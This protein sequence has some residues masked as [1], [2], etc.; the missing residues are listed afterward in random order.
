MNNH[1]VI[2]L[3]D[4]FVIPTYGRFPLAFKSGS[5][6]RIRDFEGKEYLDF[7]TGIAVCALGHANP[8]L[9]SAVTQQAQQL[10]HTSNLYYTE[11]Q[12][13]LAEKVV[14][15][16]GP[17]KCF[18]CNSGAEANEALYKLARKFGH[19]AGKYEVL[20]TF[21]SFHGRTLAGIAATGQDKVKK[22]FEPAVEGF[23]HVPFNDLAAMEKAIGPK[24]AAILIETVQGES[25][26]HPVSREYLLGLRKLCDEKGLLLMLDAVQCG[27]FRTGRF[28]SFQRILEKTPGDK[29]DF[30]P[31]AISMAKGLGGGIPIGLIWV[32]DTY[33]GIL[34][35]G[36]HGSTFGGTPIACAASLKV[37]EVIER[38]HLDDNARKLGEYLVS[39][40]Q[41]LKSPLIQEVRGIGL[42]IG[43]ELKSN[44]PSLTI[45]G[46]TAA[47]IFVQKL[48][49][50]GLLT[51][52]SGAATI[53][54]LPAMNIT[55]Q[56]CDEAVRII[57]EE[58]QK[59]STAS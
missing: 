3:Y 47:A 4:Q 59:L 31:D 30:L 41:G 29:V 51:V 5:G 17:G 38:D 11:P 57:Q 7:G 53:R 26:I 56:D 55:K 33:S 12:G 19:D 25:G 43:V 24:T 44:V 1:S 32:R 45:E 54:L 23:R 15:K 18:F 52:P 48:Q 2:S 27:V 10:V 46:K 9:A 13:K 28:V 35:P 6:S 14:S 21:N 40:I 8:E 50:A 58:L 22:G 42:M 36:T 16:V 34:G 37:F 20:T 49:E 39:K